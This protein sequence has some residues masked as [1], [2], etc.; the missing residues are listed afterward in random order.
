MP[1]EESVGSYHFDLHGLDQSL[2]DAI[3]EYPGTAEKYLRQTG[4]KYWGKG[5]PFDRFFELFS[6]FCACRHRKKDTGKQCPLVGRLQ[7]YRIS[8]RLCSSL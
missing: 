6:G 4:K 1:Y 7:F 5:H 3:N 8:F 2:I